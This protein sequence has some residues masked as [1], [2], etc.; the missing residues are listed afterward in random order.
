MELIVRS[1]GPREAVLDWGHTARRAAIG[2]R[3][4]GVKRM[5]GDG[6]TP[7][8]TFSLRRLLYRA[9]R[10]AKPQTA[11]PLDV[12]ATDDGWCDA[13]RDPAY[14]RPVKL[15]YG[16][17]AEALWRADHLYDLMV[18]VGFNDMPVVSGAG[19]AIFLHVARRD[20]GTTQG[21][22]AVA[23]SDLLEVAALLRPGDTISIR[24]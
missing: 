14:N 6:I 20:F 11:L 22:I 17:S 13:P 24:A 12:I 7:S 2:A 15:P 19:S 21:C 23:M 18:V 5:E 8:G 4:I 9:D 16:A 10:I 3:G 1:K